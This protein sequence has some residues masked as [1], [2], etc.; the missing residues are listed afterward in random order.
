MSHAVMY[1]W[2]QLGDTVATLAVLPQCETTRCR[3]CVLL[4]LLM[5]LLPHRTLFGTL[6]FLL[7]FHQRFSLAS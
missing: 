5:L 4:L 3:L 6:L 1:G 7:D 2:I